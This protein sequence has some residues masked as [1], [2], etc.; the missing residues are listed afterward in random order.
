MTTN[1]K[2]KFTAYL[3]A[4]HIHGKTISDYLSRVNQYTQWLQSHTH[5]EAEQAEKKD[6]LNYLH[7]LQTHSQPDMGTRQHT[8]GMI[9]R[10]YAYLLQNKRVIKNPAQLINLRGTRKQRLLKLFTVEEMQQL[11]D[12]HYYLCVKYDVNQPNLNL[13][14]HIALLLYIH[15]GIKP[16]E[17]NLL[18]TEALDLRK[19][20]IKIP[21]TRKTNARTLPLHATQI[22]LFYEYINNVLPA[23]RNPKHLLVNAVPKDF[24]KDLKKINLKFISFKQLRASIITHWVQTQG[25]RRAQY[26]AG[27]RYISSTQNYLANDMESLKNDINKYHPIQAL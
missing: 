7:Y 6:I 10:Y 16:Q 20:V 12:A 25:L 22:G 19:A 13:R 23:L 9:N 8:L 24:S 21:A 3:Q 15:Q 18:N 26:N 2:Q 17:L 27:H 11:A 14:N 4:H 5:K 1:E